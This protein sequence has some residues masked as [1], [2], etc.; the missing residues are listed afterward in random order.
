MKNTCYCLNQI[1]LI[2]QAKKTKT[3]TA[4][5]I[6]KKLKYLLIKKAITKKNIF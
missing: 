5:K 4:K 2:T 1:G 6:N 3:E